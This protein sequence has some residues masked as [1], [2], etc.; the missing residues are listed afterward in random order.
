VLVERLGRDPAAP[1]NGIPGGG[2]VQRRAKVEDQDVLSGL[3]LTLKLLRGDPG[4]PKP[5]EK[6]P[7]TQVLQQY[8]A[9]EDPRPQ[10]T[11]GASQGADPPG[12]DLD[13]VAEDVAEPQPEARPQHDAREV[14]EHE[15]EA[16]D[17]EDPRQ[18]RHDRGQTRE[19]LRHEQRP[20][21]VAEK[22]VLGPAHTYI[23]FERQA[24]EAREH[25][26]PAPAAE[27]VPDEIHRQRHHRD[28][29][30]HQQWT[31]SPLR[32]ERAN[33]QEGRHRGQRDPDLLGD[34]QG[35]QDED[36]VPLEPLHAVGQFHTATLPS[37]EIV[38]AA[39]AR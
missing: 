4:D 27:F 25:A 17:A 10:Q 30:D 11:R 23:G 33:G 36:A 21:V 29:A 35:R 26:R 6:E 19:K 28:R 14:V 7:S 15:P 32:R 39:P 24:A 3:E 20:N 16:G 5:P 9:D 31:H 38:N 22:E 1:G 18:G 34:D 12:H 2:D 8:V 37:H 13:G